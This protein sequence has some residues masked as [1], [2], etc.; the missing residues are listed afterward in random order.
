MTLDLILQVLLVIGG[1]LGVMFAVIFVLALVIQTSTEFL[2]GKIEGILISI[3]PGLAVFL[4]KPRLR[5]GL[6]AIVTC[7]LGVVAAFLYELDLIFLMSELFAVV[8][9]AQNPFMVTIFGLIMTGLMLGMG[10]G[11]LHELIIKPLLNR[12]KLRA[13][14]GPNH[15][16]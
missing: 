15:A 14:D 9:E 1:T 12:A 8:G 2:F 6:I 13:S 10:A 16:G 3:F 4:E 5:E 11:Y 7:S